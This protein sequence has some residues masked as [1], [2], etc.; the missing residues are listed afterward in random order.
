MAPRPTACTFHLTFRSSSIGRLP[1][2]IA[3][4]HA[5]IK[6][7]NRASRGSNAAELQKNADGSVDL[8]VGPKPLAGKES[9]WI[10]TDAARGFELMVRLYGPTKALFDKQWKLSDVEQ[11]K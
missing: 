9:N 4:S 11:V 1:L 6:N 5:L 7:V 10:P 3:K 8:Y 2:T